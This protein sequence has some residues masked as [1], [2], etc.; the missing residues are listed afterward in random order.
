LYQNQC[1]RTP[2]NF[3]HQDDATFLSTWDANSGKALWDQ[4]SGHPMVANVP[5]LLAGLRT[6]LK[7]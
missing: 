3:V 1:S 7:Q 2:C 6:L 5:V 4:F